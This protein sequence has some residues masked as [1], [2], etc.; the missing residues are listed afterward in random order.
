MPRLIG[1]VA[2]LF[3]LRDASAAMAIVA[4]LVVAL[5]GVAVW[6]GS[7]GLIRNPYLRGTLVTLTVLSPVASLE[8][9]ASGTYVLWYMLFGTFW[10]LFWRPRTTA[11]ALAGAAFILATGLS[12][13]GVWFFAPVALL[14]ALVARD[15]RDY[16]IVGSFFLGGLIQ[17]PVLATSTEENVSPEWSHNIWTAFLQRVIDGGTLGERVGGIAWVHLGW[18]LLI[19]LL[20]GLS[21]ALAVGLRRSGPTERWFAALAVPTSVVMFIAS[22]YERAVGT[23]MTWP[24]NFH[25]GAGGRYLLVPA[26]LLASVA[27]VIAEGPA[28]RRTVALG[29]GWGG[30][31]VMA[32]LLF[33]LVTSFDVKDPAGRGDPS[34]GSSVTLAELSCASG[35]QTE[36]AVPTSPPGFAMTIFCDELPPQTATPGSR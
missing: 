16:L 33:G 11:A 8:S 12:S 7:G 22:A 32:V 21:V 2:A 31:G 15:R 3:G 30:L 14:R 34:W 23:A 13:P 4:T 18:I 25:F 17:L 6:S 28:K 5:A 24:A 26:L 9:V 1:A 35:E 36:V 29:L 27:M 19:G 20:V 10:L